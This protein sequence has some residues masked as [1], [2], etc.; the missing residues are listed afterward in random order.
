M[1]TDEI[2]PNAPLP[3]PKRS[4]FSKRPAWSQP[5]PTAETAASPAPEI[6]TSRNLEVD[7][8]LKQEED[9]RKRQL[10]KS[11]G[12][13]QR[14]TSQEKSNT[15]ERAHGSGNKSNKRRR[16]SDETYALYGLQSP[17]KT[18]ENHQ[19]SPAI[20]PG[21]IDSRGQLR[22]GRETRSKTAN[23]DAEKV[24]TIDSDDNDNHA[25]PK[26]NVINSSPPPP[27]SDEEFPELLA[28]ARER[29]RKRDAEA[30]AAKNAPANAPLRSAAQHGKPVVSELDP[31]IKVL[32]TSPLANTNPLLV[33]R[34][35]SQRLMEVRQAW[36]Q[37]Q[38]FT[39]EQMQSV[40]LTY[41]LRR[42]YDVTTC[43]SLGI[44][45]NAE[46]NVL[47]D[48]PEDVFQIQGDERNERVHLVALTEEAFVEMK[49]KR[50]EKSSVDK[51]KL[52]FDQDDETEEQP[53]CEKK[54]SEAEPR[55]RV[56]IK[57]KGY[58]DYKLIVR[59]STS[60][61]RIIGAFR[62]EHKIAV[63]KSL[64]LTFDGE[65]LEPEELVKNTDIED[66]DNLEIH[67]R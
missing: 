54:Q 51:G 17:T 52:D 26:V 3:P 46:G 33:H 49:R 41:K 42:L 27:D 23:L 7:E 24:I 45:V 66:M 8:L 67:V 56:L 15:T 38:S 22:A 36:C 34:R 1:A 61:E 16:I 4:L 29:R 5:A 60:C 19:P 6:F 18:D 62:R 53:G 63:D 64:V 11:R 28:L 31:V 14:R 25:D 39:E 12:R 57:S 35:L 59:P 55:I 9:Q 10:E 37:R 47:G 40:F 65:A 44:K 21:G 30:Q 2:G 13:D 20:A 48:G 32:I 50:A 58:K 43:K